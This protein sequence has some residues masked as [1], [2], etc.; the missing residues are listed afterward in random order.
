LSEE[1]PEYGKE[2][3]PGIEQSAGQVSLSVA[4]AHLRIVLGDRDVLRKAMQDA[5]GALY[6]VERARAILQA[7][8]KQTEHK[9]YE[10]D[11][12]L[13]HSENGN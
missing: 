1:A 3:K 6:N 10:D 5:L 13:L 4:L 9:G 11:N 8:I 7:A 12:P 2:P